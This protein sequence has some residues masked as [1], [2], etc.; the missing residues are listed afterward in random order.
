MARGARLLLLALSGA[1]L[2]VAMAFAGPIVL[3]GIVGLVLATVIVLYAPVWMLILGVAAGPTLGGWL[4]F[5]AGGAIPAA[6]IDRAM[7]FVVSVYTGILVLF[8]RIRLLPPGRTEAVMAVFIVIAAVSLVIRGGSL[9]AGG[10]SGFRLDVILLLQS[11]MVPFVLFF[12]A[13]NLIRDVH[14]KWILR[15]YAAVGIFIGLVS[16]LQFFTGITW[17]TPTRYAVIHEG[18]AVGTLSSASHF[19]IVMSI[20]VISTLTLL[21]RSRGSMAKMR[22]CGALAIM[23]IGLILT[24]TRA[25][26]LGLFAAISAMAVLV[27]R[28]RRAVVVFGLAG[29]TALL[30]AWPMV[31][32]SDFV[33]GRLA[34]PVPVYNRVALWGTAVNMVIHRPLAGFGFGERTYREERGPYFVKVGDVPPDYAYSLGATHNEYF[35]ILVML[36]LLGFI[37][38]ASILVLCWRSGLQ[39]HR[40]S[41][42]ARP[43]EREIAFVA[44]ASLAIWAANGIFVDLSRNWYGSNMVFFLFGVVEGIRVR[45]EQVASNATTP[46]PLRQTRA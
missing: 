7:L 11:Y 2:L 6:T 17:F 42:A 26:Y 14:L 9:T 1:L 31:S 40:R 12:L 15:V 20:G 22:I 10:E 19:G 25:V 34:D 29:I 44:L 46:R 32:Q 24:K 45:R 38:F 5:S 33:R 18:R 36:G 28:T 27:P 13:K 23:T 21:V 37:P 39:V 8:R 43:W 4:D 16:I 35:N 3:V 30:V 41:D